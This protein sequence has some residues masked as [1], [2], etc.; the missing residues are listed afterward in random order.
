MTDDK[1]NFASKHESTA[2]YRLNSI[3]TTWSSIEAECFDLP[4]NTTNNTQT[5]ETGIIVALGF[6]ATLLFFS[7]I[8][9]YS[10]VNI[11]P[12]KLSFSQRVQL[13][14]VATKQYFLSRFNRKLN[15][16]QSH[17]PINFSN[18]EIEILKL[19]NAISK[20]KF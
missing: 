15:K 5:S 6:I 1:A 3:P 9:L 10:S 2:Y 14:T 11:S 16:T 19:Q 7:G 20:G 4:K 8:Q 17:K 12:A 18:E 13:S